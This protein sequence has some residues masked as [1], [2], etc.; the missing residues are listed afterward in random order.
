[1]L[2]KFKTL[3][4]LSI[5]FYCPSSFATTT[6]DFEKEIFELNRTYDI[7]GVICSFKDLHADA[8]KRKSNL[9]SLFKTVQ[10]KGLKSPYV[11]HLFEKDA[12]YLNNIRRIKLN[13]M[14]QNSS[15][16]PFAVSHEVPES[17]LM[18]YR[19]KCDYA[20]DFDLLDYFSQCLE[21]FSKTPPTPQQMNM[22]YDETVYVVR[23]SLE[24][25]WSTVFDHLSIDFPEHFVETQGAVKQIVNP[26]QARAKL[27]PENDVYYNFILN[28]SNA[29]FISDKDTIEITDM[30]LYL[31]NNSHIQDS[32]IIYELNNI[33]FYLNLERTILASSPDLKYDKTRYKVNK[34]PYSHNDIFFLPHLIRTFRAGFLGN[35]SLSLTIDQA[36]LQ[37][38]LKT[39]DNHLDVFLY[40]HDT[41]SLQLF[42]SKMFPKDTHGST[43]SRTLSA[44]S[45]K[46]ASKKHKG[47][48]GK[49][50]KKTKQNKK[51]SRTRSG[52]P[53][54]LETPSLPREAL[55]VV[56]DTARVT[57]DMT[58]N[59]D[60][61]PSFGE[62]TEESS[63][64]TATHLSLM[65]HNMKVEN[66][67][68]S[69]LAPFS[70]DG[71]APYNPKID[72]GDYAYKRHATRRAR[73][74]YLFEGKEYTFQDLATFDKVLFSM[75]NKACNI[76]ETAERKDEKL[77]NL[78]TYRI[79]FHVRD[80][81]A[82]SYNLREFSS[83]KIY[84]SGI[85]FFQPHTL[86]VKN[87]HCVIN[88]YNDILNPSEK[89]HFRSLY[90]R[91]EQLWYTRNVLNEKLKE[92]VVKG[93]WKINAT[94]SE[95]IALLDLQHQLPHYLY[96]LTE[97]GTRAIEIGGVALGINTYRD[98]CFRCRA[99][100]QGWQ[101]GLK[102]VIE[103]WAKEMQ[104]S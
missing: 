13:N 64:T 97:G 29:S 7:K 38:T 58:Q 26:L 36:A 103:H 78:A 89:M 55:D 49:A 2:Y 30:A 15:I 16:N 72:F 23:T 39:A 9:N 81:D 47:K 59:M 11:R 77:P 3:L 24:S 96:Q 8:E 27:T 95:S 48:N 71:L 62:T 32:M 56:G 82:S 92:S 33:L 93:P 90:P 104:M 69:L 70:V 84:H 73:N 46:S 6:P 65:M 51:K 12:R 60:Q 43:S 20:L 34:G 45:S 28:F 102:D 44:P 5:I 4:F 35:L 54:H 85:S 98:V 67:A 83:P 57:V 99:L 79:H 100:I 86:D 25:L 1:M 91:K 19:L 74:I 22:F 80:N 41:K 63:P 18:L 88:A 17:I 42:L 66:P 68:E 31:L 21:R 37:R 61:T 87:T 101:W 94:D 10:E 52:F 53:S 50:S 40:T 76:T 75:I 14:T